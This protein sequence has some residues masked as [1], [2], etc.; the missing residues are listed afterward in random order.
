[1]YVC[2]CVHVCVSMCACVFG[3]VHICASSVSMYVFEGVHARVYI[4]LDLQHRT[5]LHE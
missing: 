2:E 4:P 1:M 3:Y 5:G